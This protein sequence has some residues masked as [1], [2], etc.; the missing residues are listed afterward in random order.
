MKDLI[1]SFIADRKM[2]IDKCL[3][4]KEV[5]IEENKGM[6]VLNL[7]TPQ[8][9]AGFMGYLKYKFIND[10]RRVLCRGEGSFHRT[11][12][13]KL[14]REQPI[15][16]DEINKRI[17]ILE[18]VISCIPSWYRANRFEREDVGPLLQHYGIRT[19]WLD[20]VD[21]IFTAIWFASYNN[22]NEWGYIKFFTDKNQNREE[23]DVYDLRERHS[24]LSLRLHCQHGLSATRKNSAWTPENID[25][26]DFIIAIVRIPVKAIN[27]INGIINKQYMF[28]DEITDNTLKYLKKDKF[29]KK[30]GKILA[31]EGY[32]EDFLGFIE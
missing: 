8:L 23:L 9:V 19:N 24:S 12:I 28:P 1:Q 16:Q 25:L 27:T 4:W 17:S 14:F 5:R 31:S 18:K 7:P 6:P 11:T 30:V 20:L 21:N 2:L 3:V 32:N 13:P 10:N 29:A 26:S 22:Q 15:T